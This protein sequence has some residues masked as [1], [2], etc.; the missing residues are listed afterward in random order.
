MNCP[1]PHGPGICEDCGPESPSEVLRL[2]KPHVPEQTLLSRWWEF[3]QKA[4]HTVREITAA[5]E[6]TKRK[7]EAAE[8]QCAALANQLEA[9]WGVIANAGGGNW[10]LEPWEWQEA[11]ARW[12]DEYHRSRSDASRDWVPRA[13]LEECREALRLVDPRNASELFERI[14]DAFTAKTGHVAPGRSMPAAMAYLPDDDD[15]RHN[16]WRQF[17]NEWHE[18]FF[19]AALARADE[20]LAK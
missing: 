4:L 10:K 12:R 5:H 20:V 2:D 19:S 13:A 11:A 18:E 15:R 1:H 14:A 8:K 6:E 9:A 7:L 16:L 17:C 3:E